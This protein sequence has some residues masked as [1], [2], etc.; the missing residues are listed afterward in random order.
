VIHE[1][2]VQVGTTPETRVQIRLATATL[3]GTV[4]SAGRAR[5]DGG[6]VDLRAKLAPAAGVPVYLERRTSDGLVTGGGWVGD[7]PSM[8]STTVDP[9]GRFVFEDLEPGS[10]EA[11]YRS[12]GRPS[13]TVSLVVQ[14]GTSRVTIEVPP[15]ELR[16]RVLQEDGRAAGF[17][18]VRVVD[19]AGSEL[20]VLSDQFGRFETIGVATGPAVVT[21][22]TQRSAASTRVDVDLAQAAVVEMVLRPKPSVLTK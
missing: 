12:E 7:M 6:V 21:A 10:Y 1:R 19:A 4:T 3:Q 15:G 11:T 22:E 5:R 13:K 17:M 8:H 20:L 16:G 14:P 9:A 2:T 18:T